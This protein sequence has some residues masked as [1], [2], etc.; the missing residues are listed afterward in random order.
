MQFLHRRHPEIR[1]GLELLIKPR[2]SCLLCSDAQE[3][4]PCITGNAI[5]FVSVAVVA[6]KVV[7]IT[8]MANTVT[9]SMVTVQEFE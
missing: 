2:G 1:M 5:K 8:V 6:V 4:G 7:T 3:I 9:V